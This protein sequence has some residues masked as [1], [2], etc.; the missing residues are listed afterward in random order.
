VIMQIASITSGLAPLAFLACP[1][2][3]G[4]VMWMMG[5]E[6]HPNGSSDAEQPAEPASLE[7][8]REE[9]ERLGQEIERLEARLSHEAQAGRNEAHRDRLPTPER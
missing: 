8:L 4:V 3:M 2:G 9:H 5:R 7:V 1:V 6:Q